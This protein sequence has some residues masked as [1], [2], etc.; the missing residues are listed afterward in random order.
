MNNLMDSNY[1]KSMEIHKYKLLFKNS[2][3]IILVIGFN[4]KILDC[5]NQAVKEY[6]YSKGELLNLKVFDLRKDEENS[7]ILNQLAKALKEEIEFEGVH[8]RKDGTHFP[9]EIRSVGV[10]LDGNE[11]LFSIIRNISDKKEKMEKINELVSLVNLSYNAI[12]T[13]DREGKITYWNQGAEKMFGY[14]QSEV[15]GKNIALI[16]KENQKDEISE[17]LED[18]FNSI[19]V[20]QHERTAYDKNGN[21]VDLLIS[22][23]KIEDIFNKVTGVSFIIRDIT[24]EKQRNCEILKLSIALEQ[25]PSAVVITDFHGK[26][27]Y[28]NDKFVRTTGYQKEE[29]AGTGFNKLSSGK[30]EKN[31]FLEMLDTIKFGN[32]WKGE[33][34]IKKKNGTLLWWSSSISPVKDEE[35]NIVSFISVSE[36]ITEKKELIDNLYRKNIELKYTLELLRKSQLKMIQD[37]KMASIGQLSAGIAHEINNPLGFVFSNVNILKKY[38]QNFKN[39]LDK[40]REFKEKVASGCILDL[41]S[42]IKSIGE[43]EKA[44][45]LS[46][47]EEDL[48]GLFKDTNEGINRI[49]KI[50]NALRNFAHKNI[51][52]NKEDYNINEGITNTL[53]IVQNEIK[54]STEVSTN[55]SEVPYIKANGGEINQVLLNLIINSAHAVKEK[56]EKGNLVNE[57]IGKIKIS[58]NY[59]ENFVYCSVEDNG[60][61]IPKEYLNKVLEPFF[62]T[63]P[64]GKGTGLGLS[65]SYDIVVDKHKGDISIES[66]ENEWTR[67]TIKLPYA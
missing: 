12:I 40:Y 54:Y 1:Y 63:K 15:N 50:I 10:E 48:E 49:R 31:F 62:T 28:V 61:G 20:K 27:E 57:K 51:K 23:S 46:F 2:L 6:G 8:Y 37:D 60:I 7:I 29:I 5:N 55:L 41:N 64:V 19:E 14:N 43:V 35:N 34:C 21:P 3:D 38:I 52:E 25:S 44:N 24:R 59:D 30:K 18:V 11:T 67:V 58:S 22:T 65:I 13:I 47:I 42:E 26:I 16:F 53:V 45:K 39:T 56:S 33:A 9:V 66:M 32:D 17:I 4:G 36:D